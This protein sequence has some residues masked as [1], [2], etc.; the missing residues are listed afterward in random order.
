MTIRKYPRTQHIEGSRLQPGDSDLRA[1][2]F[3]TLAGRPLVI[4]E[5]LDGANA[6]LSF[7]P[8]GELL[9]QSRGHYLTGGAREKHF[10]LFK[11]WASTHQATFYER[12]GDRYVVYGEWLYAK[13]TI[14]YD[15]LPHYF[16]EFDVLDRALDCFLST[17]ARRELLEG[18][19]LVAVPVLHEG[20]LKRRKELEALVAPSLY[21]SPDWKDALRDAAQRAGQDPDRIGQETDPLSEAEGLYVKH[22]ED[23]RVL[24][25]YKWVR[26]SFLT[27]VLE[28]GSHWLSRPIVPNQLAP[29]ADPFDD[30][31]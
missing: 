22:E 2:P 9:L 5:K 25:R 18:L 8:K 23:G 13:H 15:R 1:I 14:F 12:L 26:A 11:T 28:S 31:S 10:A 17:D 24:G 30:A 3:S 27:S 4:E 20:P 7:R 21:K 29:G 16:M 6:A 19:P